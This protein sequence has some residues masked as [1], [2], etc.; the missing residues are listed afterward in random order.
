MI[1]LN[2]IDAQTIVRKMIISWKSWQ[3]SEDGLTQSEAIAL[4]VRREGW[5]PRS[6][7][8]T[9]LCVCTCV[10]ASRQPVPSSHPVESQSSRVQVL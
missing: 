8:F 2:T 4:H 3:Y 5:E 7:A 9:Y 1:L 6:P 10:R